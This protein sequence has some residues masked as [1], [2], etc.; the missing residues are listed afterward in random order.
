MTYV[1]TVVPTIMDGQV[2]R[3]YT[4]EVA[5]YNHAELASASRNRVEASF[6]FATAK[7]CD[8]YVDLM[9]DAFHAMEG[10]RRGEDMRHWATHAWEGLRS[11]LVPLA[12]AGSG[13]PVDRG[14][15]GG[16]GA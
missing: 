3:W 6:S 8:S 9:Q 2:V 16:D 1:I 14:E 5:A 4:D 7:Q 15:G 13:T 10:L 11:R 12:S